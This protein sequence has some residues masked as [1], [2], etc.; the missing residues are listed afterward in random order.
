MPH[1]NSRTYGLSNVPRKPDD[2]DQ[3][4]AYV[5]NGL[6]CIMSGM[7]DGPHAG[8]SATIY[9]YCTSTRMHPRTDASGHTD[10]KA[11]VYSKLCRY[12]DQR[13]QP[14]VVKLEDLQDIDL[15]RYYAN[16]WHQYRTGAVSCNRLFSHLNRLWV[17][18]ERD[19]GRKIY[20]VYI[21]PLVLWKKRI[22]DPSLTKL[23]SLVH[24]V[25]LKQRDGELID[26]GAIVRK[27]V[28]SFILLGFDE[29]DSNTWPTLPFN[30]SDAKQK[31]PEN[32]KYF[33]SPFEGALI[34]DTEHYY[35]AESWN[36]LA[37]KY[38]TTT[39]GTSLAHDF[40]SDYL[41]KAERR[42]REEEVRA[43][44]DLPSHTGQ[45]LIYLCEHILIRGHLELM[46]ECFQTLLE[47]D[48]HEDLRRMYDLLS[49]IP[50]SLEP[51]RKNFEDYIKQTALSSILKLVLADG[52][53]A[54]NVDP[55]TYVDTLFEIH[56]KN[57]DVV[58]RCFKAD[59]GFATSLDKACQEFVNCNAVTMASSIKSPELLAKYADTLLRKNNRMAEEGALEGALNRVAILFLYLEDKDIFQAMYTNNLSQRLIRGISTSD[60]REANMI[61]RLKEVCGLEYGNKLQRMFNDIRLS[62]DLTDVFKE[63]TSQNQDIAFSISVLTTNFWPLKLPTSN[64]LIPDEIVPTYERFSTFYQDKYSGR[65]LTWL[66]NHSS[67]ELHTNY[68]GQKH[69]LITSS[70][71]M[72]VLLQYNR[73]DSLSLDELMS[74]TAISGDLKQILGLLVK[75][76]LL[77][78]EQ[79]DQ[80]NLNF[81]FKPRKIRVNLNLPIKAEVNMES[82]DILEA[83]NKD[84]RYVIR[85]TIVRI[86]KA[87][88]IMKN[89]ALIQEVIAQVSRHFPPKIPVIKKASRS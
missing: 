10:A 11:V 75:A 76:K 47:F 72:A 45:E 43:D 80:Y 55:A 39:P 30:F 4:W 84:R 28:D 64:F 59:V 32:L 79:Q 57:S 18:R 66:W 7:E 62:R 54:D 24:H 81:D 36:L 85:A 87:R 49:R 51:M 14:M 89:Q 67:N 78:A 83:V 2:N 38:Y 53:N 9:S 77:N 22:F 8:L 12:F 86:M 73:H 13:L 33:Y 35:K 88:K 68:L 21:V 17:K 34:F 74:A 52:P 19:E 48:N 65:R 58:H 5:T 6:D 26:D 69:T 1:S 61:S 3:T 15:L 46:Y 60:D 56:R 25:V 42:L 71:Q 31:H 27:L 40:L 29:D 63:S 20:P 16:E 37:E 50:E 82:S 23:T 70:Y 41:K 44:R